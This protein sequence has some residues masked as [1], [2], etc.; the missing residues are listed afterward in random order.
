MKY[1]S[2]GLR[3][4]LTAAFVMAGGA[5][6]AG[7]EMMVQTFDAVGLGQWFRYV[8]G[9]I[10]ISGAILLWVPAVRLIGAALLASTSVG[11]VLAHL[12]VLGPSMVPALVLAA[13]LFAV[14][15]LHRDEA[16]LA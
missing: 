3:V 10:E 16:K 2:I 13:L 1:L 4:L 9:I 15:Y 11:A 5:K 14:I 6:L 7:V 12:L 8:T